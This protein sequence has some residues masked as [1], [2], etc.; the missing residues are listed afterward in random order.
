M[1]RAI[2]VSL[3]G[4]NEI[5]TSAAMR[6]L[7][8]E[9]VHSPTLIGD[10][11]ANTRV[12]MLDS[13]LQPV[14]PGGVAEICVASPHL[15]R[16]YLGSPGLTASR[17]VADPWG[18]AGSRLYRSGDLARRLPNGAIEFIGRV[19]DQVKI[20]GF[21]VEIAEVE[22]ALAG[23]HDVAH[24]AVVTRQFG[25]DTR[26]VAYA[27]PKSGVTLQ[28]VALR[29]A[30]RHSLPSYMV[31]SAFN[32][33]EALPLTTTGKVDR[34]ALRARE[35]ER[36]EIEEYEAP[37]T[38]LE[39]QLTTIWEAVLGVRGIG[40]HDSFVTLGGD[41]LIAL[42]IVATIEQ[43]LRVDLPAVTLFEQPTIACVAEEVRGL[44]TAELGRT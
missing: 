22:A 4:S 18:E 38:Q 11:I 3:Y 29:D 17:F 32:I 5:G 27:V 16:G 24:A 9:A 31:P 36:P 1:P 33:V 43:E 42:R 21:R 40:I 15:A 10:A 20:R 37:R 14:P 23:H 2:L 8:P 19:D 6:L 35:L 44:L 30:I 41:S 26:L 28:A 7:T 25:E 39:A 12:H 13:E 34:Q